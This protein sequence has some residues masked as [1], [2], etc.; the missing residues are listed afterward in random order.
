VADVLV[1]D[2]KGLAK[3]LAKRP[4]SFIIFELVQNTWDEEVTR[5]SITAEM[6]PGR[7]ICRIVVEDDCPEGFADIRSVYTLFRDSKKAAD[8]SK[9]G[10]FELGEK[11]VLALAVKAKITTTK[12]TILIEGDE[13]HET[14]ERRKVGTVFEGDFKMTREE[15]DVVC[16]DV[17]MLIPPT[18]IKTTFNGDDLQPRG[19]LHKF[20]TTLQTIRVDE[21]GNLKPTERKAEV[22]IYEVAE[23]EEPHIYE[24]GVPVVSTGDRWHYDVQQRVPVNWERNNVPPKYIRTLR[25]EVLNAMHEKVHTEEAVAPWVSEAIDDPRVEAKAL[26]TIITQRFGAKSVIADP[27]DPEGTKIAVS[28]GY[29]VISGGALSRGAWGNVKTL[30][31]RLPAGQVTPSPKPYDPNGRPENVIDQRNW[32]PDMRRIAEFGGALFKKLTNVGCYVVIVDEPRA[33]WLANFG[34][35][36]GFD[37]LGLVQ[38]SGSIGMRLCLNYGR[39]GETWFARP[40]RDIELLDL[41][42]HEF[43]HHTVKDHLSNEMHETATKLGAKLTNIALDE[44]EFFRE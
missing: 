8:P 26:D 27:S 42:I 43:C 37:L 19:P 31:T 29:T 5:V 44:P 3:K 10:R 35:G 28:Q 6:L 1:V 24:M 40:K 14:S 25:V 7:P 20:E 9:R 22:R 30:K 32:T 21:E 15:Y 34:S 39:L 17:S 36:N 33:S 2:R 41:L 16:R 12:G 23:G 18:G 38:G 11:L 13:R 4:K